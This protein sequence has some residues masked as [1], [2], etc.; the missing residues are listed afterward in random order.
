MVL[1]MKTDNLPVVIAGGGI[2]G[3]SAGLMLARHGISVVIA[4]QSRD[5]GEIGAGIQIAPNAFAMFDV[6]GI[7]EPVNEVAVFPE[8]LVMNDALSGEQVTRLPLNDSVFK[9][10]FDHPY[11][12]IYRPDLHR[13]L[14]NAASVME[15][16]E[17]R[18]DCAVSRFEDCGTH[19]EVRTS[20][21]KIK[22]AALI[23]A[24]GL[25]SKVRSQLHREPAPRVSGHIAY[26][27]VL[28]EAQVPEANHKN[29]VILWAGPGTHL[30]HYPLHR[31]E[32]FNLVAVFHSERYEEG[33]D[34]YGDTEELTRR[35]AGQHQHVLGML[36][37]IDAWRMWV[38]CDR[39]PIENWSSGRVTLLGDA[40][41]PTLQYLAQGACMAMEDAVCIA[42]MVTTHNADY[43]TAFKAYEG[44]RYLRTGR[45]QLTSRFYGDVYHA[46][47]VAAQLRQYMLSGRDPLAAYQ[48]MDWL[49]NGVDKQGR[50]IL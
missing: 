42:N 49:Y 28:N 37:K 47:H 27:A 35:F 9:Q 48:G 20:Q 11:A 34:I 23:G 19:V 12:V 18:T 26:R 41:H 30:V 10:H 16:V 38:L 33:W 4:E 46:Q 1:A 29:E 21:G 45:V 3:I 6:M 17:L 24:D 13:I 25:W 7:T 43:G 14:L 40:A 39:E 36:D 8:A 50:Q 44:S 5:F 15:N 31:G 32:I 22:A 2:G